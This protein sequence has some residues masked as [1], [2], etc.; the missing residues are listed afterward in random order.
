MNIHEFNLWLLLESSI[1]SLLLRLSDKFKQTSLTGRSSKFVKYT[2][3]LYHSN[4][5]AGFSCL[6]S[7]PSLE[8]LGFKVVDVTCFIR[9]NLLSFDLDKLQKY[10]FEHHN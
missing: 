9:S 3:T 1:F 8:L 5:N 4:N 10:I 6:I 2:D 7:I